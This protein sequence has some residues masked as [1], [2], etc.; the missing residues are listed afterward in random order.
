METRTVKSTSARSAITD[1]IVL[2]ERPSVRLV[3]R[4]MLVQNDQDP[5]AGVKGTFIYQRKAKSEQW[6]DVPPASLGS[7]KRGEE[8]RLELHSAE[9]LALFSELSGLYELHRDAGVPTGQTRYVKARSTVADLTSLSDEALRAVVEGADSLGASAIARLIRWASNADNFSLLFDRLAQVEPDG[10]RNLNAALGV[11]VLKRALAVWSQNK[12]KSDE[13]FWQSLLTEQ[14]FVL[15]QIFSLPIVV[16][17]D[18]AYVGG[19]TISNSGGHIADFLVKNAVTNAI[20]LVEIKTPKTRLLGSEYR[21][22]V[23]NIS[24]ELAG[25]IQQVLVYRQSLLDDRNLLL[26]TQPEME[27]FSPRCVVVIGHAKKELIDSAR[28]KAF[29]LFRRQLVDVEVITYDEMFERTRRLVK[30]LEFGADG[31]PGD[32]H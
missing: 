30:I 3:F 24:S 21:N 16:I 23:Y 18:R 20:G 27:S 29:E 14:V 13:G 32:A 25:S 10:L 2:R 9:L 6:E 15:E 22:G 17:Q 4:P 5:S 1:D 7:L 31:V 28:R 26:D 12:D 11:A 8:Y 19:K